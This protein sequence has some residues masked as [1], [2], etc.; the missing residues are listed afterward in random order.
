MARDTSC[1]APELNILLGLACEACS[2]PV[3]TLLHT[4]CQEWDVIAGWRADF[5]PRD[6]SLPTC[7][8]KRC[9]FSAPCIATLKDEVTR[10]N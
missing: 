2:A 10:K 5:K 1:P 7:P 9:L 4:G 6:L 8:A 3:L